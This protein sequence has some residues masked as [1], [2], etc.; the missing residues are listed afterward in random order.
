MKPKIIKR[1]TVDGVEHVRRMSYAPSDPDPI[2][3][4]LALLR[5]YE[6]CEKGAD[7]SAEEV[8]NNLRKLIDNMR[9]CCDV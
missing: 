9:D 8:C 1:E 5:V 7:V 3:Q 4:V 2:N 6:D